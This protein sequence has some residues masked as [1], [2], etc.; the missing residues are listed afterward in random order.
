MLNIL[1]VT[2]V[3]IT[4]VRF[5]LPLARRLRE[6]GNQVEFAF[7]PGEGLSEI[8]KTGFT[9]TLLE[10]DKASRSLKNVRV[11]GELRKIIK[12]GGYDVVHTYSPVMG[13]YGRLA[14]Y[15]TNVSVLIHSVIGSLLAPGVPLTHRIMY[16]A[17]ELATSR[18][19]DLFI[20]LNDAD[21]RD[22]VRYNLTRPEKVVSLKYEYGVDLQ[23]FNPDKIDKQKLAEIHKRYGLDSNVPVIGFIGRMIDA[24]GILDLFE[25]Y[26]QIRSRGIMAKLVYLGD[27]LTTDKDQGSIGHLKK[28]VLEQGLEN[29]VIFLGFQSDVPLYISLMDVVVLPSHHEGFPRI[30]VEA[31]AMGKPSVS[32][33]TA[34]ADVAID[35]G[36]TGFI[37]PIKNP[38][39]LGDAIQKIITDSVLAQ[40]MGHQARQRVINLFDQEKIVDQQVDLY[41]DFLKRSNQ[42][43]DLQ[44]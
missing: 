26:C 25:A 40:T 42:T 31:G 44:L 11:V 15:K 16:I 5:I 2:R 4:A 23:E 36:K 34:G 7:G 41:T 43:E 30:P 33:A 38:R 18:M 12:R 1:F 37:V 21:A 8:E 13:I 35:E 24:K 14:A 3:P 29:E 27:V 10:M 28:Q 39:R 9:Y 32:T 19:V 17:S 6:R 20:T 22:M